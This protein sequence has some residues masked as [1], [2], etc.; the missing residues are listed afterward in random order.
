MPSFSFNAAAIEPQAPRQFSPLPAGLYEMIVV[1]SDIK[2]TKAGTGHYLELEMQVVE[3]EHSGRRHWERLNVDNPNKQA[4]DIAKAALSAL[5]KAIDM[6]DITDTEELHDR[7]FVAHV[8][9][10]R[11]EPDRNRI[12]FYSAVAS[13]APA[14]RP[15]ASPKP[16]AAGAAKRP[17]A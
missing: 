1:K 9:I 15:A 8:E 11:K 7:P 12:T 13:A 17:W 4:E 14:A 3:G 16:A 6:S 2:P 5:C 10:D